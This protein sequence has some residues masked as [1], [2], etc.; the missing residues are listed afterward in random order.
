MTAHI[1]YGAYWSTPF[2]RWQGALAHLP[3]VELAAHVA[4]QRLSEESRKSID[5]GVL[6]LTVPQKHSFYGLPWLTGMIGLERVAGPTISQACATSARCLLVASQEIAS[7]LASCALVVACDRTSNGPHLYYPDPGGPGGTG[8]CENWVLDNFQCDPLGSHSML[9]TAEKIASR[10]G[11]STEDQHQVTLLRQEQYRQALANDSA[12]CKTFMPLPFEVPDR[13]RRKTVARLEQDEGVH[14]SSGE[15]LAR[16]KPV[17]PGGTVT[18]AGQTHP[19]DGNAG[20]LVCSA[21][22][23]RELARQP[24]ISVQLMG[25]GQARAELAHMPLAPIEAA[26][27]ALASVDRQLSQMSAVKSHNPFAVN[28]IVFARETGIDLGSMNNYGCSLVY[29][30]PQGPTGLRAVIELIEELVLRGGG[31]G[32]FHGC[33]AGDSAMAVVLKVD[34]AT[35]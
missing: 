29:G 7:G 12:F 32:L 10:Y 21:E 33:S 2:A 11:I 27:R 1:P 17:A 6:G 18:F 9:A 16:L 35:G 24:D 31:W 30:H 22:K 20:M 4:G 19:A 34:Q 28:D 26:Q 14:D 8:Q 13:R 5:F 15:E 23:A 3:S 25:F